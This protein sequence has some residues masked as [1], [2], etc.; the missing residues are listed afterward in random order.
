MK[1]AM[2]TV[3]AYPSYVND[4]PVGRGLIASENLETG[5]VV[6]KLEGRIVPYGKIPEPDIRIGIVAHHGRGM[7]ASRKFL[8]GELIERAPV[9][10]ID[11][12]QWPSAEKTI[13]SN[14]AFDWG[15]HDE[16][17]AI[18]FGYISIY[19]HSYSPNAQL[20]QMPDELMMEIIAIKDIEADEQITINYNGDPAN[21]DALWFTQRAAKRRTRQTAR[22]RQSRR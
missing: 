13:L 17:A 21:Q 8:K 4:T 7:F 11:E 12:K 1:T 9:I 3:E 20:E 19:N 2:K 14:Y 18:A 5:T 10:V 6:E 22:K 16:H 15:E